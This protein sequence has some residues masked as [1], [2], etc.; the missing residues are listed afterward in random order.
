MGLYAFTILLACLIPSVEVVF[1]FMAAFAVSS[2]LFT[3]PGAFYYIT[4][5]RYQPPEDNVTF[6]MSIFY[7]GLGLFLLIF[8]FISQLIQVIL[9]A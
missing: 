1:G 4:Y 3:L 5:K 7:I 8:L 2:I 9:Y 6:Y